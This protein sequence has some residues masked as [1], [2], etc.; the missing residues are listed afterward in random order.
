MPKILRDW[1]IRYLNH[2]NG[3][4]HDLWNS[5]SDVA[6]GF[7]EAL[8][9]LRAQGWDKSVISNIYICVLA[10]NYALVELSYSRLDADGDVIPPRKRKGVYVVLRTDDGWRIIADYAHQPSVQISCSS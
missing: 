5:E 3:K 10:E 1:R 6:R 8:A 4:R 2:S 7:V 9:A